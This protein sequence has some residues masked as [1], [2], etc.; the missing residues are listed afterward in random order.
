MNVFLIFFV[1]TEDGAITIPEVP[2]LAG[3]YRFDELMNQAAEVLKDE[4]DWVFG[5][6]GGF[7]SVASL[8]VIPVVIPDPPPVVHSYH[9]SKLL[10]MNLIPSNE[11][12]NAKDEVISSVLSVLEPQES[13]VSY[14]NS[15]RAFLA[16][17]VRRSLGSKIFETGLHALNC[18]LPDDPIRLTILLG[19]TNVFVDTWLSTLTEKLSVLADAKGE[20][21]NA[22]IL[23]L[24][25]SSEDDYVAGEDQ[26]P[27]NEHTV[28]HINGMSR[29][30]QPSQLFCVF[31]QMNVEVMSNSLSDLRFLAFLEEV[32]QLV[33][34]N[35]L[36]K[37][38][39]LLIR[40]W[41][42]YET[43]SYI[44]NPTKNFLSDSVL[45]VLVCSIFNQYH[46]I[47]FQPLQVLSVFLAEYCE[48][49]WRN[50]TVTIQG[51]V[52]FR[53]I[54]PESNHKDTPS[55]M[56]TDIGSP[57]ST[58]GLDGEPWLRYPVET[59]L[60]SVAMLQKHTDFLNPTACSRD[61][62]RDG[63]SKSPIESPSLIYRELDGS[64]LSLNK[65]VLNDGNCDTDVLSPSPTSADESLIDVPSGTQGVQVKDAFLRRSINI[66]NP[67]NQTNMISSTMTLDLSVNIAKIFEVGAKN[68]GTTL[69]AIQ[70]EQSNIELNFNRFFKC[71]LS[72]FSNGW[73][74]DVFKNAQSM[75][76]YP[77]GNYF[78]PNFASYFIS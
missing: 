55:D 43:S 7:K 35:E 3:V 71:V 20:N 5:E 53:I 44:N 48:L 10:P 2:L 73:R 14:R 72:R 49:D 75:C 1:S 13:Q 68:L 63:T 46:A 52:P 23:E 57:V 26:H 37:R 65:P 15:A 51:I 9:G 4:T 16:R 32:A 29:S 77:S 11:E 12:P 38:S 54:P 33:G 8:D 18:F 74:P 59:D 78:F 17:V 69:K 56:D 64:I 67:L 36:F 50:F 61:A 60:L 31:E 22:Q 42:T 30:G 62:G 6:D 34:K 28:S 66:S 21:G 27:L 40:G 25:Q 41:W 58:P 70:E 19:R 39:L 45:S 24:M 76:L 47:L